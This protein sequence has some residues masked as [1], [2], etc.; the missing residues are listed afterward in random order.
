MSSVVF[1]TFWSRL[2]C[3][4]Q[5]NETVVSQPGAWEVSTGF[6]YTAQLLFEPLLWLS[7]VFSVSSERSVCKIVCVCGELGIVVGQI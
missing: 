1:L 2:S 7:L 5:Y 6:F 4:V 3:T